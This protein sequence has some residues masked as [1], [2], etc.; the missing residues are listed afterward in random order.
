MIEHYAGKFPVWLAPEQIRILTI[1]TAQGPYAKQL[2]S[3]FEAEELRVSVDERDEK[4]GLKI[5]TAQLE[6]TPYMI[7][8]GA[9]EVSENALSVR[10]RDGGDMGRMTHAQFLEQIQR[11]IKTRKV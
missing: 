8:V 11:E 1:G 9:K 6:K 7:I 4:I 10:S 2:K 3:V 5:R